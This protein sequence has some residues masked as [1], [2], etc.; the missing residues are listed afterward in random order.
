MRISDPARDD[1]ILAGLKFKDANSF[2]TVESF[3]SK[4]PGSATQSLETA[5]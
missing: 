5:Q 3:A 1:S 4:M 2:C